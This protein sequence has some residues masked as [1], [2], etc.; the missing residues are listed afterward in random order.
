MKGN[1]IIILRSEYRVLPLR[2][3]LGHSILVACAFT[4]GEG[5]IFLWWEHIHW[6]SFRI[7][8]SLSQ[9]T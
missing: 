3:S 1:S 7:R 4:P 5:H 8:L 2:V 6:V 9:E